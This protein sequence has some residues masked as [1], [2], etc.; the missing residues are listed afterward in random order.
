MVR[1]TPEDTMVAKQYPSGGSL[2]GDDWQWADHVSAYATLAF[3][4]KAFVSSFLNVIFVQTEPV[5]LI[6]FL[7]Q[8]EPRHW[9]H[10]ELW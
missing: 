3:G 9:W 6:T 2:E 1:L 7:W 5:F 10:G 4:A 8:P